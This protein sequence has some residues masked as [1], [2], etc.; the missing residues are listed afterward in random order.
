M[1]KK[2]IHISDIH[3]KNY[4]N[5]HEE[6]ND[7]FNALYKKID[8]CEETKIIVMTGDM[9]DH[10]GNISAD[11]VYL[12]KELLVTLASKAPLIII[13]GNHDKNMANNIKSNVEANVGF[14]KTKHKIY[15][16]EDETPIRYK[17]IE[18]IL[19]PMNAVKVTEIEEKEEDIVYVGLHHGTLYNAVTDD[20][21]F[22]NPKSLKASDFTSLYDL[23]L[24]GDIHKFQYMNKKK[25]IG[26]SGSLIQQNHGES[27]ENHG[28]IIWDTET[29]TSEFIEIKN[30]Y[31]FATLLLE[32]ETQLEEEINRKELENK[33]VR[34]RVKFVTKLRDKLQQYINKFKEKYELDPITEIMI[35]EIIENK[36]ED[37]ETEFVLDKNVISV[38][39]EFLKKNEM[40]QD[41]K[42]TEKLEQI[43]TSLQKNSIKRVFEL[44]ELQFSNLFMYGQNNIIKFEELNGLVMITDMAEQLKR[45]RATDVIHGLLDPPVE[46]CTRFGGWRLDTLQDCLMCDTCHCRF[47][48]IQL[49]LR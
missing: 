49:L 8:N 4:N 30:K 33:L 36:K 27:I 12:S 44:I 23:T 26:Y 19:T 2:I 5:R 1:V 18:F 37:K 11:A 3:I 9:Y 32:N 45:C 6:Y 25:T 28:F 42:V 35:E 34:L 39:E 41:K 40:E 22:K 43:V 10:K 24:L 17:N 14:L 13:S 21:T 38:Y 15:Y 20:I 16:I 47:G 46:R 29:L 48:V 31:A 7:I